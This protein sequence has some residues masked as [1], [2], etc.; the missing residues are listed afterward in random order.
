MLDCKQF[1]KKLNDLSL[2]D[3]YEDAQGIIRLIDE[4]K[5]EAEEVLWYPWLILKCA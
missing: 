1:G 3:D 5:I 4:K 2:I